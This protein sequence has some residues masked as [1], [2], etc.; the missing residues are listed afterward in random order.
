MMKRVLALLLALACVL[1]MTACGG[2]EALVD[3]NVLMQVVLGKVDFDTPIQ[4]VGED[5]ALYFS[6]LPAGATVKMYTGSGYYADRV[7][8]ITL[9]DEADEAAAKSSVQEHIDQLRNQFANYIPE[10]VS[11]IDEAVIWQQGV[12]VL[13]CVT[14]DHNNAQNIVDNAAEMTKNLSL[15]EQPSMEN[16]D[17]STQGEAHV[18]TGST[19]QTTEPTENTTEATQEP[20]QPQ[21]DYPAIIS[22]SGTYRQ[23]GSSYI[24]DDMAFENYKYD[25]NAAVSYTDILNQ[26]AAELNGQVNMYFLPIPTAIGIVLPDD[27]SPIMGDRYQDQ[28][29]RMGL[30]FDKLS[31]S[32]QKVDCYDNLMRHRD[33]YLYFRTDFH[34]NGK[35]AYY[36]YEQ[37]CKVKGVTPYTLDQRELTSFE[38]FL[39]GLYQN[40]CKKDPCLRAD[41]VEA[42]HPYSKNVKM[43]FTDK[44]GNQVQWP[45]I[46]NVAGSPASAKYY[47]FAGSDNPITVF[48]NP[49]VTDGSVGVVIKES[50]GNALMPYMCDHYS[51]LYE[52]D[53]RYWEGDIADFCLQ[54]GADDITF[55]NNMGMIRAA[56]LVAMLAD[57]V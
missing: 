25:E 14:A 36:A 2:R 31:D 27:I 30:L 16:T 3:G 8:L 21:A 33:E 52:I 54:V 32:V 29:Q 38:G 26:V 9:A 43:V 57:N 41:T 15:T 10:E 20:T 49:D 24:V 35:A 13:L 51:T 47:T 53:Y 23:A 5:A 12:Y 45:I 7:A 55:A 37:W 39:G 11:K 34:W 1:A 48:T 40:D 19:A 6:N 46:S 17:A 50:F 44:K 4:D 28:H 22:Q 56:V 18:P 42:Y